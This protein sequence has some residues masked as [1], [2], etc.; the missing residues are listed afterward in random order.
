[1]TG[2]SVFA[3]L[4]YRAISSLYYRFFD[5]AQVG[6]GDVLFILASCWYFSFLEVVLGI[7]CGCLYA[8]LA[9]LV[10]R[11]TQKNRQFLRGMPFIPF[12]YLGMW[13]VL[14]YDAVSL[15]YLYLW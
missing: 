11:L 14:T 3:C 2:Y 12:F 10:F 8:L 6:G 7:Y 15:F 1:M 4:C 5:V 9:V 13:T